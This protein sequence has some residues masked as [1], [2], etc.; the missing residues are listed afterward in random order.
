MV[1]AG[2]RCLLVWEL[3]FDTGPRA[4]HIPASSSCNGDVN[5]V[6]VWGGSTAWVED[7]AKR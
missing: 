6:L 2:D 1:I 5:G 7:E 4:S 3:D